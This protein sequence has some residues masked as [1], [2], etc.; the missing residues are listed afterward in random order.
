MSEYRSGERARN[1][2]VKAFAELFIG[3]DHSGHVTV[4][5]ARD[6]RECKLADIIHIVDCRA[7]AQA[8]RCTFKG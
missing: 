8:D 7:W 5:I 2:A 4:N 1:M 6:A 3:R